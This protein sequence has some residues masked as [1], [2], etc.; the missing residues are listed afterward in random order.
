[1]RFLVFTRSV[2]CAALLLSNVFAQETATPAATSTAEGRSVRISFLP[3]PLEGTISLG[4]YDAK[5]KL[6]RVLHREAELD[7]FDVG[8]DALHTKWDGKNDAGKNVPAGKYS[9]RGFVVGDLEVEE[10]ADTVDPNAIPATTKIKVRLVENVLTPGDRPSLELAAGF[11]EDAGFL[12]TADGLPLYTVDELPAIVRVALA[13]R[14]DKSLDFFE[15]DGD[16]IAQLH[17]TG[18]EKMMAFDCGG[19]ELK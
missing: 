12:E 8:S 11:D 1:M 15:D 7:A 4:I 5:G 14:A 17:V 9:A 2:A 16:S 18:L 6:V 19:F 10:V 13:Q 3:P